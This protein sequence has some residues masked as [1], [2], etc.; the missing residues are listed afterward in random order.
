MPGNTDEQEDEKYTRGVVG[1]N[2]DR[3]WPWSSLMPP[4]PLCFNECPCWC[5]TYAAL[6]VSD[7]DCG[8]CT[9]ADRA[10][11]MLV[12]DLRASPLPPPS[13]SALL[14]CR[15]FFLPVISSPRSSTCSTQSHCACRRTPQQ[16]HLHR[17]VLIVPSS[18][19]IHNLSARPQQ[20]A[21][22]HAATAAKNHLRPGPTLTFVCV[23]ACIS[24]PHHL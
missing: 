3:Q 13:R 18:L 9:A 7:A 8:G 16:S 2:N 6:N 1:D 4:L 24:S 22:T 20:V 5:Q 10:H 15:H 21:E 12:R 14:V 17:T 19:H 11:L 23:S